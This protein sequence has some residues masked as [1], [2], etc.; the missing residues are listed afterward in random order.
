MGTDSARPATNRSGRSRTAETGER[1]IRDGTASPES[2]VEEATSALWT[3]LD[4]AYGNAAARAAQAD[5]AQ[6]G[7]SVLTSTVRRFERQVVRGETRAVA[8]SLMLSI[9]GGR[10]RGGAFITT[11]RPYV[12]LFVAPVGDHGRLNWRVGTSGEM[13][14]AGIVE[15]LFLSVFDEQEDATRRLTPLLTYSLG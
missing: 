1:Q 4:D 14:T 2:L 11:S 15:D 12:S 9:I 8:A 6:C 10:M 7:R 5:G 3:L 13:L